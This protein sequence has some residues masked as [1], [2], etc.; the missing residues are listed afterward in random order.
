MINRHFFLLRLYAIKVIVQS[1]LAYNIVFNVFPYSRFSQHFSQMWLEAQVYADVVHKVRISHGWL[2]PWT[3]TRTSAAQS[4][5]RCHK[6]AI[7]MLCIVYFVIEIFIVCITEISRLS[8]HFLQLLYCQPQSLLPKFWYGYYVIFNIE[9]CFVFFLQSCY[10]YIPFLC[11]SW[12][13]R[14]LVSGCSFLT[15]VFHGSLH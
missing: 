14:S 2:V 3:R 11:V 7:V 8:Q 9:H 5:F 15:V 13:C 4:L 6:S 1:L 12:C 10:S